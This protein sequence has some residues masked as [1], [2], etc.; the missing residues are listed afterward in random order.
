MAS[1][2]SLGNASTASATDA[3]AFYHTFRATLAAIETDISISANQS[4]LHNVLQRFSH[5]R[6]ELTLAT[7][8]GILP[9]HDR[10]LHE[11]SLLKISSLLDAKRRQLSRSSQN[12]ATN[13]ETD[14]T[15]SIPSPGSS[16]QPR[17]IPPQT[18]ST[19]TFK[20][21]PKPAQPTK[22]DTHVASSLAPPDSTRDGAKAPTPST[23]Q[24]G[25]VSAPSP[26]PLSAASQT[27][28]SRA[29][30]SLSHQSLPPSQPHLRISDLDAR[31]PSLSS[32]LDSVPISHS[33]GVSLEITQVC[34]SILDLRPLPATLRSAQ[35]RDVVGSILVLPP[36]S[37]SVMIHALQHSLLVIPSCH[38]FRIHESSNS[39]LQLDT[40]GSIV[41]M[42]SCTHLFIVGPSHLKVQDFDNL[43]TNG[44]QLLPAAN[45][46]SADLHN[47]TIK[48]HT[49]QLLIDSV[50]A[51]IANVHRNSQLDPSFPAQLLAT[52]LPSAWHNAS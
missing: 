35:I 20:R 21:T 14:I 52:V 48:D 22:L 34:N 18:R 5:A 12:A 37:G 47:F 32:L 43:Y 13:R 8:A 27:E 4:Q 38:Q 6:S 26:A 29:S 17:P 50:L 46:D 31:C 23:V 39:T 30:S 10:A 36:I 3:S 11:R 25:L 49:H 24:A 44:S 45:I 16:S 15:P 2:S 19:F 9:A 41:T 33:H 51:Q 40:K 42:E 28:P 7:T 1:T